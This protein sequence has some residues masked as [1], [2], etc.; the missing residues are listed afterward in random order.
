[1][2]FCQITHQT[3]YIKNQFGISEP[4]FKH[5]V[6]IQSRFLSTVFMPLVAFDEK[7]NR[8][9]MG[10]GFYDRTF[11]FKTTSATNTPKLI[12]LAYECQ[13]VESLP[14]EAWDIPMH[15]AATEDGFYKF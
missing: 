3:K 11:Q 6:H 14:T 10:G 2:I 7:G 4:E 15:G 13:K 8:M 9:G 1:M 5:A 12:G